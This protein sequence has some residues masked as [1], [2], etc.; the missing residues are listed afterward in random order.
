MAGYSQQRR[1]PPFA[2][3]TFKDWWR[4]RP[5][6]NEGKQ[7]VVLWGDTFSNYFQPEVAKAAVDAL[8]HAGCQVEVPLENLCCGR[9]LYDYGMLDRAKKQLLETL[10]VM[11]PQIEAGV[12]V[13][14]LE[15]SCATVFRDEMTSLLWGNVDARRLRDQVFLLS[16][17][18]EK[19]VDG[20][21]P[22]KLSRKVYVHGH[23]HHKSIMK[24]DDEAALL[25]KMGVDYQEIESG[26]CGMAGAF[27]YETGSHY[28]VSIACGERA[29]LPAVRNAERDAVIVSDGF[30]CREQIEQTTE[31]RGLHLSQ[32]LQMAIDESNGSAARREFPERDYPAQS[33]CPARRSHWARKAAIAGIAIG[34]AAVML[35]KR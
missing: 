25:K 1:L 23:C 14:V 26:C 4:R 29:L 19:K 18:L 9:P 30:S 13:V 31:R 20:Y 22:P 32:V 2:S 10:R 17:F 8:E 5:V 34:A 6:R 33:R 28:E 3:S 16:E 35:R 12:P 11:R 15:P 27:G 21:G 7:K 24:M